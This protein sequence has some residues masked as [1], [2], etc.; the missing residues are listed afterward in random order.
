[1]GLDVCV[2]RASEELLGAI[3]G[4]R[5]GGVDVLGSGVVT[6][7]GVAFGV[8]VG[9]YGSGCL[10]DGVGGVVLGCDEDY[11]LAQATLLSGDYLSDSRVFGL[12]VQLMARKVSHIH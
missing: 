5:F 10:E 4:E 7:S 2:F 8:F 1:M 11:F 3:D 9:Q 12:Q 6:S